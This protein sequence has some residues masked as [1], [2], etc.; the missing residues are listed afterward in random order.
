ML[1]DDK[2]AG[3]NL[4]GGCSQPCLCFA[5]PGI[6]LLLSMSNPGMM[7]SRI[8]RTRTHTSATHGAQINAQAPCARITLR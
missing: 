2:G 8:T 7:K 4:R 1:L 3:D 6:A 5:P